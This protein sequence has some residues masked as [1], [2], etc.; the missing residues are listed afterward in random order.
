[1]VST[2]EIVV[3]EGALGGRVLHLDLG[4]DRGGRIGHLD[5]ERARLLGATAT[6]KAALAG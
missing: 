4:P 2:S 3:R 1:V 5:I 6:R